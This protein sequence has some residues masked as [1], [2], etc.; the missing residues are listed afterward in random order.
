GDAFRYPYIFK[1]FRDYPQVNGHR[2][3]DFLANPRLSDSEAA[4]LLL[5]TNEYADTFNIH[6]RIPDAV[7]LRRIASCLNVD[8][9]EQ[10]SSHRLVLTWDD[11][12]N[13]KA[14]TC[15]KAYVT[16]N[17]RYPDGDFPHKYLY[18]KEY[19]TF[20]QR[21]PLIAAAK[22]FVA[23]KLARLDAVDALEKDLRGQAT[24]QL[25]PEE[26]DGVLQAWQK[27]G[28]GPA[29]DAELAL[30][31]DNLFAQAALNA[32]RAP[33]DRDKAMTRHLAQRA[34]ELLQKDKVEIAALDA[35]AYR[36]PEGVWT[37]FRNPLAVRVYKHP[38]P[39]NQHRDVA[40]EKFLKDYEARHDK[41]E[42]FRDPQEPAAPADKPEK[43]AR[44]AAKR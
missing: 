37:W 6:A 36:S 28:G 18:D 10:A 41:G 38:D 33:S 24:L 35:N 1:I 8:D 17:F 15:D 26:Y 39:L 7:F 25:A 14:R 23:K 21:D 42:L 20:A 30:T 40:L 3:A 16:L 43:P 44:P 2:F 19:Q 32:K 34:R 5:A 27:L 9:P 22:E 12:R 11:V 13:I 29:P 4:D 31:L